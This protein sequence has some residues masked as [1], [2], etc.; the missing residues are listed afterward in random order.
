MLLFYWCFLPKRDLISCCDIIITTDVVT[1]KT[2]LNV[3]NPPADLDDP[4]SLTPHRAGAPFL[5]KHRSW[6]VYRC[7]S[8]ELCICAYNT[9]INIRFKKQKIDN[10]CFT[11]VLS[12][13]KAKMHFTMSENA[14][15]CKIQ[16]GSYCSGPNPKLTRQC[17][18]NSKP[19]F[20]SLACWKPV[21]CCLK[22]L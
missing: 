14:L 4:S 16:L 21:A 12:F 8:Q 2:V 19:L 9:E 7:T 3:W 5:L 22:T 13:L 10:L 15:A 11:F 18:R 1:K 17:E 6:G 20:K